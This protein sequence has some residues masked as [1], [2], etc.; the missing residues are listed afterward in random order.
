MTLT[1]KR[2]QV[3]VCPKTFVYLRA[4]VFLQRAQSRHAVQFYQGDRS[5]CGSW[6]EQQFYFRG[7][8]AIRVPASRTVR[9]RAQCKIERKKNAK[10]RNTDSVVFN[11]LSN[12]SYLATLNVRI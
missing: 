4:E 8:A 7:R 11:M 3:T 2:E 12:N 5:A 10:K 1:F 9:D 6:V